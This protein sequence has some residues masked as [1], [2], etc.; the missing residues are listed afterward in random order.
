MNTR[1]ARAAALQEKLRQQARIEARAWLIAG[2]VVVILGLIT[3]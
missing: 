2:I 3:H 1:E